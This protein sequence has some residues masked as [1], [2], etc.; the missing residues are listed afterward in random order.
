MSFGADVCSTSYALETNAPHLGKTTL[1]KGLSSPRRP[2][3]IDFSAIISLSYSV[4]AHLTDSALIDLI[5]I[6]LQKG[7]GASL[8]A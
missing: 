3:N 5:D 2:R 7:R 8:V 6:R 1:C 4:F